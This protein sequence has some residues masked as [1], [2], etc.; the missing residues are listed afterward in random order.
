MK[1]AFFIGVFLVFSSIAVW[2]YNAVKFFR[3]DFDTPL[4]CE[5]VHGIGVF[6]PPA[7]L[8]TVWFDFNEQN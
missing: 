3:C 5:V 6:V 8:I 7:S 1:S 2:G 4:K